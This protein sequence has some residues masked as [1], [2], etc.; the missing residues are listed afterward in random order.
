MAIQAIA[1]GGMHSMLLTQDGQ[2]WAVGNG[3]YGQLC[4]GGS[5]TQRVPV[6]T[7]ASVRAVALG[8][9]HSLLL[10]KDGSVWVAGSNGSGQIGLGQGTRESRMVWLIALTAAG[11][12]GRTASA[13]AWWPRP[14][15]QRGGAG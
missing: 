11:Y 2:L 4:D 15:Q 8:G 14:V 3:S 7:I 13:A 6:K 10:K 1:A 9:S 12:A 5:T